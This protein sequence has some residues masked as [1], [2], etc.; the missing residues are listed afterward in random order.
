VSADA[1]H[2]G[3]VNALDFNAVASNFGKSSATFADGDFNYD[4]VVNTA[5]FIVLGQKFGT[6]IAPIGSDS[7]PPQVTSKQL[8][9]LTAA[10]RLVFQFSENVAGSLGSEDLKVQNV[11]TGQ[12]IPSSG[13]HLLSYDAQN[14]ATFTFPGFPG[15]I[16][17]DGNYHAV[18]GKAGV[19]D[20]SGNPLPAD[21]PL[22]FFFVSGDANHDARVNALDFNALATSFGRANPTFANG[23]FNYDGMVNTVDFS[24]FAQRFGVALSPQPSSPAGSEQIEASTTTGVLRSVTPSQS[25]LFGN[26]SIL[27]NGMAEAVL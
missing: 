10:P 23:D 17:D 14:S 27:F 3:R 5:D 26:E 12:F 8:S 1:N 7:T 20:A 18:L 11:T 22:D 16:I 6:Q 24:V 4:G 19:N 21:V 25:N 2:D 15:G 9:Y 13:I